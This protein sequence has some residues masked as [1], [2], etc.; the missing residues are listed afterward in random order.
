M[1]QVLPVAVA[2]RPCTQR[3]VRHFS[4]AVACRRDALPD[5]ALWRALGNDGKLGDRPG[6]PDSRGDCGVFVDAPPGGRPV[7]GLR[8]N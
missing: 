6:E 4:L 5:E 1:N 3:R 2:R 7:S 8:E